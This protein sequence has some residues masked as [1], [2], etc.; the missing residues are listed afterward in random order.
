LIEATA[1]R[2]TVRS[3]VDAD[4]EAV[5]RD[6]Q[7]LIVENMRQLGRTIRHVFAGYAKLPS[8]GPAD[9][10]RV[11]P[12][13]VCPEGLLLN[14]NLWAWALKEGGHHL[15]FNSTVTADVQPLVILDL[16]DYETLMGLVSS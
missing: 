8:V 1:K 16:E 11:W 2:L 5:R 9:L 12:I 7:M 4:A 6:L 14:P 15:E 13:I 3:L 10:K